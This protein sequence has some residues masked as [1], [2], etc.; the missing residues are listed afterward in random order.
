MLLL[1]AAASPV[2]RPGPASA[3][4]TMEAYTIGSVPN[5]F[6]SPSF[7]GWSVNVIGAL[8][9]N[10]TEVGLINT[11]QHVVLSQGVTDYNF[12]KTSIVT[13]FNSW[14]GV[15]PPTSVATMN[16]LGGRMN[17]PA[18]ITSSDMFSLSQISFAATGTGIGQFLD[19]GFAAGSLNYSSRYVGINWGLDGLQ[20][21]ADDV[22]ITSGLNTQLINEFVTSGPGNGFAVTGAEPGTTNQDKID[23]FATTYGLNTD[24]FQLTGEWV[25]QSGDREYT[26]SATADYNR[27][28]PDGGSTIVCM[29]IALAALAALRRGVDS[30]QP[31]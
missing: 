15:A 17:F 7:N 18:H 23:V 13:S 19:F 25:L 24:N 9:H 12:V 5:I 30:R 27:T 2:L 10:Q 26:A 21:T 3:A 4:V 28:V 11:P 14:E 29:G 31:A 1:C 22:R 16:E 6:G 20:G 8:T